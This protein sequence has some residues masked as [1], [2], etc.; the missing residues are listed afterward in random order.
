MDTGP[1]LGILEDTMMKKQGRLGL[2]IGRWNERKYDVKISQGE[3]H[4]N[5]GK[6]LDEF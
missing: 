3:S 6:R 2:R 1:D 5:A 4:E